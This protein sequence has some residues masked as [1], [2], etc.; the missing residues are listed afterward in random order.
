MKKLLVFLFCSFF[1][2]SSFSFEI[3]A[4]VFDC[5]GVMVEGQNNKIKAYIS[6][7]FG[8]DDGFSGW[9]EICDQ[10]GDERAFWENYAQTKNKKLPKEWIANFIQL[11][12]A[13]KRIDGMEDL[14][15]NLKKN[16]Y[17]VGM[18]SNTSRCKMRTLR[19]LGIYEPFSP[20]LLSPEINAK[21]NE[22]R[23]YEI[24]LLSL[25][26][27]AENILFIDNTEE[28]IVAAKKLLG[29]KGIHFRS[30]EQLK[31]ELKKHGIKTD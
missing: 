1:L 10:E 5:G 8:N 9:K 12:H 29:I 2:N 23:A 27:P 16:G 4:I 30:L 15:A 19:A 22:K 14:V 31:K 13:R 3:K 7:L 26:L 28:N 20:L 18:L 24:L 11:T 6:E 25:D 21:K 17:K